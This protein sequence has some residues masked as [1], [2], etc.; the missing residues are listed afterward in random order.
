MSEYCFWRHKEI[1]GK[2]RIGHADGIYVSVLSH[3]DL[4]IAM[5]GLHCCVGMKAHTIFKTTCLC[6]KE[7]GG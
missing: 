7:I 5:R 2:G 1:K 6:D 4:T 3:A